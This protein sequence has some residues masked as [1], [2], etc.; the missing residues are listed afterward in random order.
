MT[1]FRITLVAP[2]VA[3]AA[4]S[5]TRASAQTS[6]PALTTL[7]SFSKPNQD[8]FPSYLLLGSGGVL[9][10]LAGNTVFSLTPPTEAGGTWTETV[11]HTFTG[12]DGIGPAG[13][14][15]GSGGVL[16]GVTA[17]GG[18]GCDGPLFNVA[19]LPPGAAQSS[20]SRRPSPL[21]SPGSSM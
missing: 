19:G 7:Y 21:G 2:L 9:Y 3:T 6:E 13:L 11:L 10:G 17:Q 14:V 8:A 5:V 15:M 12:A 16:Y 4:F 20:R 1:R 18:T